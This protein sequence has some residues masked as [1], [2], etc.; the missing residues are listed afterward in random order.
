MQCSLSS[1]LSVL[2][3]PAIVNY[4]AERLIQSER[5]DCLN[6]DHVY[7]SS[8]LPIMSATCCTATEIV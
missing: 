1:A 8:L 3:V 2:P 5:A 7:Q 4:Y 6:A